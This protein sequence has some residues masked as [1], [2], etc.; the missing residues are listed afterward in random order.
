MMPCLHMKNSLNTSLNCLDCKQRINGYT[1]SE[2]TESEMKLQDSSLKNISIDHGLNISN[3]LDSLECLNLENNPE[4]LVLI[5]EC[6]KKNQDAVLILPKSEVTNDM[7][8][9]ICGLDG[10]IYSDEYY[11]L[12][13]WKELYLPKPTK[14]EVLGILESSKGMIPFPQWV[15][16]V[17]EDGC[18]YGYENE[19]LHLFATSLK[20]LLQGGIKNTGIYYEYPEDLSDEDEE[21]LQKDEEIQKIRETTRKFVDTDGEDF[22]EILAMF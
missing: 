9:R 14:M 19:V 16:L 6:V 4:S 10:T 22:D 8:I 12:E 3:I 13:T 15:I 20:E 11:M 1:K 2:K 7:Y 18:V 17:G 5:S 21:V